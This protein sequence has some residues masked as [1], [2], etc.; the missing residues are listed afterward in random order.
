[1]ENIDREARYKWNSGGGVRG[2]RGRPEVS[3]TVDDGQARIK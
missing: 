3:V 1:M 2:S